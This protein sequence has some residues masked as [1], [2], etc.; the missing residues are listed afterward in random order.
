MVS[1]TGYFPLDPLAK[2][3]LYIV[4]HDRRVVDCIDL[5]ASNT[6]GELPGETLHL[7]I[8]YGNPELRDQ[9]SLTLERS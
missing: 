4:Q 7:F 2:E 5:N 6:L 3:V 9:G 8:N 1:R